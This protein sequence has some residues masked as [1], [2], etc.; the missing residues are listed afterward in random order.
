ME[1]RKPIW[2]SSTFLLYAGG[3][4]VLFAALG[5]LTYLS[6]S[7]GKGSLVAWS[8]L[9]LVVL[10]AVARWLRARGEWVAAGIFAFSWVAAWIAFLG[11]LFSWWGWT[12]NTG[13]GPFRGWHWALW[14][15]EVLAIAVAT[16]VRRTFRFPL[17][18]IYILVGA[19]LLVTDVISGGGNWSAFVTLF[20]GLVYLGVGVSVDGGSRRPYGFWWHLVSGLLV[21]GALLFWWHSTETDWALLATASVVFMLIAGATWR[22]SWAVLGALGFLAASTHWTIE[23][24][25]AGFS[26]TSPGR[27]WVPFVVLAVVGFFFVV[28]GLYLGWRRGKHAPVSLAA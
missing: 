3:F 12:D 23:W 10:L 17:V 2:T 28:V 9:P 11:L 21:G 27:S 14:A 13:T 4:A 5:S 22:S 15:V 8:L 1:V 19:Y 24:V 18:S 7:Y 26:F 16:V 25:S 20:I 6:S